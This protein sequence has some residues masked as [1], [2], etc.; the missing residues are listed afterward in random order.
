MKTTVV[1]IPMLCFLLLS[2]CTSIFRNTAVRGV[3]S[4]A[5]DKA[6]AKIEQVDATVAKLETKKLDEIGEFSFGVNWLLDKSIE[7]N[8]VNITVPAAKELNQRVQVLANQPTLQAM[9]DMKELASQLMTNNAELLLSKDKE[10][11]TLLED[12]KQIKTDRDLA[13]KNYIK[14]ADQNATLADGYR[15]TLNKMD[16]WL[17][18][19]AVWYGTKKFAISSMWILGIGSILFIALRILSISS[20]IASG[21][22]MVFNVIGSW[23]VK[24]IQFIVPKAIEIAGHTSTT[25]FEAY[26]STLTKLIDGIQLIKDRSTAS[27]QKPSLTEVLDEVAKT[28][29]DDEKDIILELKKALNWTK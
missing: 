23:F 25:I 3:S 5:E 27:G 11:N 4:V 6:K 18:L 20:P 26:K 22:F 7:S 10:I 2:G 21:I 9:K 16:K 14:I 13:I 8:D 19:G 24:L 15:A 12:V 1:L 17:G 28:M 29:N